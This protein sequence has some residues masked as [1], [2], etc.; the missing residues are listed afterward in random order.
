MAQPLQTQL[1]RRERQIMDAIYRLGEATVAEV[2]DELPSDA[3]YD[4]TRVTLGIL[5]KKGYV[6][7]RQE[8]QRYV[9][10]P[11]I[12]HEKA[13]HSALRHLLRTFFRGSPSKAILTLLDIS[14]AKLSKNQ[15][16]EI[17]A[18]IAKARK[19][20]EDERN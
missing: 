10:A 9:Y 17:A 13:S 7:H 18:F 1:S 15:L 14:A 16:D 20:Q 2:A 6:R 5:E 19:E 4:S 11:T 3:A 8:G 12:P